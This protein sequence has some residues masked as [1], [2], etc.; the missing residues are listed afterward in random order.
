MNNF[1]INFQRYFCQFHD[2]MT[3]LICVSERKVGKSERELEGQKI[4][5]K[6]RNIFRV[7]DQKKQIHIQDCHLN[8][9]VNYLNTHHRFD[10]W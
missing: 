4:N 5:R 7:M 6:R 2:K 1:H 8:L 10:R 9:W 3:K